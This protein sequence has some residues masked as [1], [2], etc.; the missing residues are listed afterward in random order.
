MWVKGSL[1]CGMLGPPLGKK[2]PMV[3]VQETPNA[4]WFRVVRRGYEPQ[5]VTEHLR[6]VEAEMKILSADRDASVERAALAEQQ[7]DEARRELARVRAQLDS[8]TSP[9]D[10]VA[11]MSERL[12]VMLRLARDEFSALQA[13]ASSFTND[14]IGSV[15]QE[16]ER[17]GV[18]A[19]AGAVT[20]SDRGRDG[21]RPDA[22]EVDREIE[23]MRLR[24]AEERA[25]LDEAA[26]DARAR[27]EEEFRAALA[28][29][30]RTA[31]AQLTR[32]QADALRTARHVLDEAN[33]RVRVRLAEAG[34][35]LR[36]MIAEA[37]REV[38]DLHAVREQ[39]RQHI[40]SA[41]TALEH[42]LPDPA[43]Q[44]NPAVPASRPAPEL[45]P[46][47]AAE[48]EGTRNGVPSTAS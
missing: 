10:T 33:D 35:T 48:D 1:P 29:R 24:A 17:A 44:G 18:A 7:L 47:P 8:M 40:D 41:R 42:A 45:C 15:Q 12:H 25:R 9:P 37:Q 2:C 4:T 16:A 31:L 6:R 14:L 20:E 38:D 28:L 5:E 46:V 43:R 30:C 34:E 21:R 22:A 32:L 39:L 19:A 27:A 13:E 26:V 36:R 11:S 23:Q 3:A